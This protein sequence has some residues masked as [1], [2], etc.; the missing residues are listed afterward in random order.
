MPVRPS[1]APLSEPFRAEP[2]AGNGAVGKQLHAAFETQRRH[3][4]G[5]APVEQRHRDLVRDD[6]KTARE[7]DVQV[8]G[9]GVRETEV[10]DEAFRPEL[11]EVEHRI[12]PARVGPRPGMELQE[13]Q[14]LGVVR[15]SDRVTAARTSS[16]D[17]GPGL[18]THFVKKRAAAASC[19]CRTCP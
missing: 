17:T 13:V 4:A 3:P 6:R 8:R 7:R 19:R 18:G 1:R 14:P 16:R 9:V 5:G 11:V 10:G 12:E 15:L 2:A